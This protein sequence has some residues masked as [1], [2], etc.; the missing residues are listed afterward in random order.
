[1]RRV[2]SAAGHPRRG[3]P[4]ADRRRGRFEFLLLALGDVQ[5]RRQQAALLR[6]V[7]RRRAAKVPGDR[8]ARVGGG[9]ALHR[10]RQPD[11]VSEL[12]QD[13][14]SADGVRELCGPQRIAHPDP[15][16]GRHGPGVVPRRHLRV[17]LDRC[18]ASEGGRVLRLGPGG[19]HQA[20]RWGIVVGLL[21]QRVHRQ[22]RDCPRTRHLRV[23]AERADFAERN[24]RGEAG[25]LGLFQYA[26]SAED[27][28]AGEL[29]GGARLPRPARPVQRR[30]SRLGV[31]V[32]E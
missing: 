22:L 2:R 21:V 1:M 12:L 18:G 26:G 7:G 23:A 29:R 27:R 28:L 15:G 16:A 31:G 19:R 32:A 13:V 6:R 8:Q 24:R 5:Q 14:G 17:R 9:C 11:D 4:Q 30:G 10:G 25:A 3:Q 20:G